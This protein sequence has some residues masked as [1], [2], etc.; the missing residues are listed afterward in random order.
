M[1]FLGAEAQSR[2]GASDTALALPMGA[3]TFRSFV[4]EGS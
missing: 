2:Q 3:V 4:A 1:G